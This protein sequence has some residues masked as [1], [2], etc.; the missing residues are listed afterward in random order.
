MSKEELKALLIIVGIFLLF[1]IL[2]GVI[3]DYQKTKCLEDGGRWISGFV[4]GN[5]TNLCLPKD[6]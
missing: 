2:Y 1:A 3:T 5:W 6:T 4:G